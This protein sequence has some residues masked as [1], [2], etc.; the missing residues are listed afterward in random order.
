MV[1]YNVLYLITI[2]NSS[3][4]NLNKMKSYNSGTGILSKFELNYT[5]FGVKLNA[6]E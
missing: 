4:K 1:R 5:R 2:I 6:M 3:T